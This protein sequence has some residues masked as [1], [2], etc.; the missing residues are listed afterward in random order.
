MAVSAVVFV[1]IVVFSIGISCVSFLSF[2]ISVF[3]QDLSSM[4]LAEK[5]SYFLVPSLTSD[6][7]S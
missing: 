2:C 1:P 6:E 5:L 3:D 7:L 4:T